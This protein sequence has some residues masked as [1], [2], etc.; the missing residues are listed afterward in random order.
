MYILMKLITTE[1]KI[2]VVHKYSNQKFLLT[3][4]FSHI[5]DEIATRILVD[6]VLTN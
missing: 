2:W 1:T 6:K 4:I 3:A 5:F